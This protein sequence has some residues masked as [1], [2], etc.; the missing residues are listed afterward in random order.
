MIRN[1]SHPFR[2]L[3]LLL[4]LTTGISLRAQVLVET[5]LDT[6]HILIGEQ[7]QLRVKCSSPAGAQVTFP[8]YQSQEQ[9]M[10][11]VEVI[12]NGAIDTVKT[13]NGKRWEL[14]RRYTITS[15]DS[16]LYSIPPIELTVNGK[17]YASHGNVGLKVSS[18]AVDTVHVDQ[19]SGPHDVIDM[20]FTFSWRLTGWALL[21][22]LLA[23]GA[24]LLAI[25]LSDPKLITRRVVIH[26]PTPPHITA[27]GQI[28]QIK[29]SPKEDAKAYYM[30]LTETLR[31]YIEKRFGFSAREMTTSE[32][33]DEL[34]AAEQ[35]ESLAELKEVLS[36][37]DL[38][39]FAKFT[40][41]L[42]EQ[43]RSL[44]Q[45]LDFVQTT[46]VE[47]QEAPKPRVEYVTLSGNKQRGIR[48]AM[49]VGVLLLATAALATTA[50]VIYEVYLC[51]G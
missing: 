50:Y 16:A 12:R 13:N 40:P 43:D 10:P 44:I 18:V 34:C 47:P 29:Q 36:Q 32:I 17:K 46:K 11:G 7:V 3:S 25:R 51:F 22:L 37:A 28:E 30:E 38:V 19:F 23:S 20:P 6:A 49:T 27:I 35:T 41:S 4:L 21:A 8:Y 45:A 5:K 1:F 48:T 26:P 24:I 2:I 39:K 33:I 15:F 31:T 42:S 9:L 14:T